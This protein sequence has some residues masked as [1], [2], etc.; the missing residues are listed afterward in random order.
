MPSPRNAFIYLMQ[1]L[2]TPLKMSSLAPVETAPSDPCS[3]QSHRA[4]RVCVAK[5]KHHLLSLESRLFF[6]KRTGATVS[7]LVGTLRRLH[8]ANM[9]T[10]LS[11]LVLV[12]LASGQIRI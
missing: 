7:T 2:G 12:T 5:R 3:P 4:G 6:C 9:K 11:V 1:H 10:I 8:S